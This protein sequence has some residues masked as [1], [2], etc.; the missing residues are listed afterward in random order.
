MTDSRMTPAAIA[1][2]GLTAVATLAGC[3]TQA[4]P[5]TTGDLAKT[6]EMGAEE[7]QH[8]FEKCMKAE[9]VD[10]DAGIPMNADTSGVAPGASEGGDY[11]AAQT[12][13]TTKLGAAPVASDVPDDA[14]L[15]SMM[16]DM[17]KCMRA[18][19]YDMPDPKPVDSSSGM[20][21]QQWGVPDADPADI[22]RCTVEAGLASPAQGG[23]EGDTE[24]ASGSAE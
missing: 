18:A 7:W 11:G 6:A 2:I 20:S 4:S 3:S 17:A 14:E 21:V 1:L 19:G 22:E 8:E 9:G 16:L 12:A 15:T 23:A 5:G 13:C 24:G 10:L